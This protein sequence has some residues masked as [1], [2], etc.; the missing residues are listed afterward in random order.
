MMKHL[1]RILLVS[2]M[3]AASNGLF[4]QG[5]YGAT[6][7]DSAEC[8][9]NISLFQESMK[10]G[11]FGDAYGPYRMLLQVC[12]A[13]SKSLYQNGGKMLGD[14]IAKE[15][16][17]SRKE[18]LIDSLLLN[19]DMRITHFGERA[20]VMG[21]KGV[22]LQFYRPKE[23][24]AARD[25]MKEA[26]E[27]GGV[28]SE[29]ATISAYYSALNCLYG[30]GA[31]TKEQM[32]SEYVRL[33]GL[34]EQNLADPNLKEA[35]R[36]LWIKSR[37]NVNGNF[38][39]IA[40]CK[41]IGSIAEKLVQENPDDLELKTRLLR[42]LNAKDCTE[43]SIYLRLAEEVHKAAPTSESA[44]SLGQ[45]L[46]KK[47]D[48]SGAIKY[49]AEAA[50]LCTGCSDRVKYLLKAGQVASAMGNHSK[51]RSYANQVL[52][53]ESKNGEALILIGNAIAAQAGSCEVPDSWG[54]YWLAYDYY[55]RARSLDPSVSDKASERMGSC[56]ARFPTKE[57]LFFRNMKE[58]DSFQMGCGGL[59]ESTTVRVKK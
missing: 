10:Q 37:D 48:L 18:R 1:T 22:D 29:P 38:F 26:I 5:K 31:A 56:N 15:K 2:A 55:Q 59:N 46:V 25:I 34:I 41:D 9:K 7:A 16:E 20:F 35:D 45:Y 47:G 36:E 50:E 39:R 52:Q 28:R 43:E 11:R 17:A 42:V 44:Y 21:R 33:S 24:I 54:A 14:F 6:P 49:M 19:Y 57:E 13:Y 12:P 53:I 58:G 8:V 3:A 32:L 40:E 27:L 4:A 30:E 23:C 51:A